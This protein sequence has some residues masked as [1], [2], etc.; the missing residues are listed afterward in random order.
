MNYICKT[1]RCDMRNSKDY[2]M[3]DNEIMRDVYSVAYDQ[4]KLSI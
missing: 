1:D 4:A 3:I 2:F